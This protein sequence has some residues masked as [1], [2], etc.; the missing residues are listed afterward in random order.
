MKL[1]GG[2]EGRLIVKFLKCLSFV[3]IAVTSLTLLF[4]FL[5]MLDTYN[6]HH[7]PQKLHLC[8]PKSTCN[9]SS[10]HPMSLPRSTPCTF[11]PLL[12]FFLLFRDHLL[13]CFT[14]FNHSRVLCVFVSSSHKV[15]MLRRFDIHDVTGFE[16][17]ESLSLVKH[18]DPHNLLFFDGTFHLTFSI[19]IRGMWSSLSGEDMNEL[20]YDS[21]L[22]GIQFG[23]FVWLMLIHG[24]EYPCKT[25]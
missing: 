3:A 5:C 6:P 23:I 20:K 18:A 1:G 12:F 16:I 24:F 25:G 15:A 10:T 22:G 7:V 9:F 21:I 13:L 19:S 4:L 17:L 11:N 14:A 8:F 2:E